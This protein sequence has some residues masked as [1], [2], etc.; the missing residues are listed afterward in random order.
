[1]GGELIG[2]L[3]GMFSKKEPEKVTQQPQAKTANGQVTV[4]RITNET[5]SW[6]N[7]PIPQER[8]DIPVGWKKL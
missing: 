1:V 4:F 7:E 6:S 8:F 2:G 5:T 3:T